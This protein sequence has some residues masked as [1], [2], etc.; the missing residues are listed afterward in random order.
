M[1]TYA[2]KIPKDEDSYGFD[3]VEADTYRVTEGG[4]LHLMRL[5]D[6]KHVKSYS[7]VGWLDIE[8]A[9]QKK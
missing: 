3:I 2:V 9:K 8:K 6:D 5:G 1:P 7:P 4:A